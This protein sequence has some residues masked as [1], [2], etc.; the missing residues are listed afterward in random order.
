MNEKK[1]KNKNFKRRAKNYK[2]AGNAVIGVTTLGSFFGYE[3][4]TDWSNFKTELDN[5]IVLNESSLKLNLAIAFPALVAIVVYLIIAMKKNKDFFKDKISVSLLIVII[6]FWMVYSVIEVAMV[7]MIG[8]W[9]GVVTDEFVF[10]PLSKG[11]LERYADDHD[12]ELEYKKEQNRIKARKKARQE[13]DLNGS[14]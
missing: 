5:F 4:A 7:S 3:M 11:S 12:V 14:V 13:E 8:A 2:R 9:I 6:I 10:S 1:K